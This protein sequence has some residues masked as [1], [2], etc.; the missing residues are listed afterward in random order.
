MRSQIDPIDL[1]ALIII[2]FAGAIALGT[3]TLNV[4]VFGGFDFASTMLSFGSMSI[5]W[6]GAIT[7]LAVGWIVLTNEL[8][9]SDYE[10]WEYGVVALAFAIVP[11]YVLIP[12]VES[13]VNGNDLISLGLVVVQSGAAVLVSYVE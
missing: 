2:P 9:G 6:A 1:A 11:L 7:I 5:S 4:N 13:L 10:Q 3:I 8:D 12:S